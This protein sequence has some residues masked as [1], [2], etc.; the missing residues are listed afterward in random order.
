MTHPASTDTERDHAVL[1]TAR[2][3]LRPPTAA[4]I[5]A[6]VPLV[7]NP[8][9]AMMTSRIP[10]PYGRAD[11]ERFIA[12]AS[13]VGPSGRVCAIIRADDGVLMGG[14]GIEAGKNRDHELGYWLGEPYWG[15]GYATEAA[16]A[17]IDATFA[18]PGVARIEAS[19]RLINDASRRILRKC[20]FRYRAA[21]VIDCAALSTRVPVES[22]VL[23]RAVWRAARAGATA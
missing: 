9:I 3:R 23:D 12:W 19:C 5:D 2:L 6:I 18:D 8:A 14:C 15:H 20:G 1:R 13:D 10:H 17:L 11:A 7:D 21:G 16:R 4:D 22:Y